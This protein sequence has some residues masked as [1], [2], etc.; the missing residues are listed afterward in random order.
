MAAADWRTDAL[1]ASLRRRGNVPP[2][3]ASG[4][5]SDADFLSA[6][7]EEL[8][9]Y[10]VPLI[11]RVNE[12]YLVTYT[13]VSVVSGTARYRIPESALGESLKDVGI[14]DSA[15]YFQPIPRI[16][17]GNRDI[18]T[19]YYLEDE[20]IVLVPTPT[21]A[22]TMRVK[23]VRR[24]SKLVSIDRG[25][26]VTGIVSEEAT[27]SALGSGTDALI[28]NQDLDVT[29]SRPGFKLLLEADDVNNDGA[30][31]ATFPATITAFSIGDYITLRGESVV[32][33]IPAEA[34]PLLAQAAL[35]QY[36]RAT[37]QPGLAEAEGRRAQMEA[38]VVSLFSPRTENQPKV[39]IN[40]YGAGYGNWRR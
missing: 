11:R 38:D 13:D 8:R 6:L 32:P 25:Y 5:W 30:G 34:H 39:V 40:R 22:D 26:V 17:S 19:G 18:V 10:V 27:Y 28:D 36:L 24:P 31:T 23:Y 4:G 20:D 14:L 12:D 7:S 33:Q 21:K 29:S 37:S 16:D 3:S 35:C 1:I 15:G 2:S 9:S